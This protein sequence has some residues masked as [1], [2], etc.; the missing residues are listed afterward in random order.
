MEKKKYR[1]PF[2]AFVTVFVEVEAENKDEAIDLAWDEAHISGYCGNGGSD[3]LIGVY[4]S[5]IS[6]EAADDLEPISD[7]VEE[8]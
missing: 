6:I 1:V 7:G 3:K 8:L 5:N 2:K 4:G